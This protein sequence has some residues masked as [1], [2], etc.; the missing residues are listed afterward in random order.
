MAFWFGWF[1]K[2]TGGL[3]Y[4]IIYRPKYYYENKR[5]QSRRI[6]KGAIVISNHHSIWDFAVAMFTFPTRILR[7]AAAEL[8]Y[9]KNIFMTA[10]LKLLGTVR[11]DRDGHDFSFL[12]NFKKHLDKGRVVE[13]YPEARVP[14]PEESTPLE[15]K[16]SAVYLALHTGAPI[17]PICNNGKHFCKERMRVLIGTPI[18]VREMY[19]ENLSERENIVN[20]NASVRRKIIEFQEQIEKYE[21]EEGNR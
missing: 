17:I 20:I 16:T 9:E 2:L 18:D 6:K 7:C 14:R 12:S 8:L 10:F 3:P 1:V 15:F 11:V 13:I 5:I 4:L 19:D 21:K